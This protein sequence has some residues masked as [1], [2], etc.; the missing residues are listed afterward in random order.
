[1]NNATK[2][3]LALGASVAIGAALGVLYAPEEG[4][5][6]RKKIVKRAKKLAGTVSDGLEDGK[7]SLEDIKDVLQKELTKVNRKL[8]EIKF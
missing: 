5:E 1:M 2:I 6:T 8:E 4:A 7:E 3:L